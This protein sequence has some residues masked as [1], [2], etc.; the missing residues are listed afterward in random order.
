MPGNNC[1]DSRRY[2]DVSGVHINVILTVQLQVKPQRK[3][4]ASSLQKSIWLLSSDL[5]G[6]YK[7]PNIAG[8]SRGW[9]DQD[10]VSTQQPLRK[11][12]KVVQVLRSNIW[13]CHVSS[14]CSS[15]VCMV[16]ISLTLS[17]F[18]DSSLQ[19]FSKTHTLLG[20]STTIFL[21]FFFFLNKPALILF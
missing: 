14:L 3:K 11:P 9:S 21:G 6:T 19:L 8:P 10:A 1:V 20:M 18:L 16:V 12:C 4:R 2:W 7:N 17:I 15:A 13:K 5:Q